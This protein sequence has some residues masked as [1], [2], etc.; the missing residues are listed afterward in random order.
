M[1]G[2]VFTGR[3]VILLF[4]K[5]TQ[6]QELVPQEKN[7]VVHYRRRAVHLVL[8]KEKGKVG[9]SHH[10]IITPS[11]SQPRVCVTPASIKRSK[12]LQISSTPF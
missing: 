4:T 5:T 9:L 2:V 11:K 3:I 1:W 6:L 10:Q 7:V 12:S 8:Q